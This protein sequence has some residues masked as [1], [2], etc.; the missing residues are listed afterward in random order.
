MAALLNESLST[1][2]ADE[3]AIT[4]TASSKT[5][6]CES[7]FFEEVEMPNPRPKTNIRLT[8]KAKGEMGMRLFTLR[9]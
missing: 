5:P 4:S 6:N 1:S 8:A 3:A 2:R 9:L 7:E